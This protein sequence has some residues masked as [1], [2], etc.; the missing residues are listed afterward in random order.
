MPFLTHIT[1]LWAPCI[2]LFFFSRIALLVQLDAGAESAAL[3]RGEE[4]EASC[5]RCVQPL[6]YAAL[7]TLALSTLKPNIC[8]AVHSCLQPVGGGYST[9][10]HEPFE[11]DTCNSML[12]W[13][14]GSIWNPRELDED[15]DC[16][17]HPTGWGGK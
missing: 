5:V 3:H 10:L 2:F 7:S 1:A 4:Q 13:N 6:T 17:L 12:G 9:M 15:S 16:R 14:P 8:R 11:D